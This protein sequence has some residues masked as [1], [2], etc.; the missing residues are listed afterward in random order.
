MKASELEKEIGVHRLQI[1][2][3]RKRLF[4]ESSGAITEEEAEAIKRDL[5]IITSPDRF[6]VLVR[7]V[8]PKYPNFVEATDAEGKEKYIVQVPS[9]YQVEN[10]KGRWIKVGRREHRPGHFVYEYNPYDNE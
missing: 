5:K 10:F 2:R 9:G 3:V 8:N 1:G 4:P 7:Y 6:D